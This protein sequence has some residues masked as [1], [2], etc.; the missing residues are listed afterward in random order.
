[1]FNDTQSKSVSLKTNTLITYPRQDSYIFTLKYL[2]PPQTS[3][4]RKEVMNFHKKVT[5]KL[6]SRE[7]PYGNNK[8]V[9]KIYENFT[10]NEAWR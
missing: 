4:S 9:A 1:M 10:V 2:F 6:K 5:Q 8:K 7:H 3:L